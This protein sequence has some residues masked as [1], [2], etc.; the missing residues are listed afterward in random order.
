[1]ATRMPRMAFAEAHGR[2]HNAF[3][4]AMLTQ[5]FHCVIR[6]AR[7]KAAILT[8]ERADPQLIRPEQQHQQFVHGVAIRCESNK[9]SNSARSAAFNATVVAGPALVLTGFDRRTMQSIAGSAA[10]LNNSREMRLI[11][12]R[13][14][15]RGAKRLAATTPRRACAR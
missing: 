1:M 11:V 13:V 4:G 10:C 2:K 7:I 14:T 9:R 15:A 6:A 12:L 8:Q 5:C 3:P